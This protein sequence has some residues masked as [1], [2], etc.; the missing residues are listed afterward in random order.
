MLEL[1]CIICVSPTTQGSHEP[2]QKTIL[3]PQSIPPPPLPS[4][5]PGVL[6][7]GERGAGC[8][9]SKNT[10]Q[11]NVLCVFSVLSSSPFEEA[12]RKC[13]VLSGAI[14]LLVAV[15]IFRPSSGTLVLTTRALYLVHI[16]EPGVPRSMM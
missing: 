6:P 2:K 3:G 12:F 8:Q 4:R 1:F 5:T 7:C 14:I 16:V 11:V 9:G 10:S 15:R 13:M